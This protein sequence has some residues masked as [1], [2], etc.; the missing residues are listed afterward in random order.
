MEQERIRVYLEV[1][2]CPKCKGEL[3]FLVFQDKEGFVCKT[4]K[5]LYPIVEDIPVMLVE[6]A[7][8]LEDLSF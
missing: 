7:L 3:E 5:L 6:E 1:L 2:A 4:C 8:K